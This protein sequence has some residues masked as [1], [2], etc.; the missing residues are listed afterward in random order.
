M[1]C[2]SVPDGN[3]NA[4]TKLSSKARCAHISAAALGVTSRNGHSE[5]R[6]SR[7]AQCGNPAQARQGAQSRFGAGPM[8]PHDF[9]SSAPNHASQ[10]ESD[11]DRIIRVADDRH[12]VGNEVDRDRQVAEPQEQSKPD[13]PAYG[14]IAAELADEPDRV[15][16]DSRRVAQRVYPVAV[17]P[18]RA[19]A[20]TTARR[21][22]RT[23]R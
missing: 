10:D 5:P 16:H 13:R 9:G 18:G 23:R 11:D 22:R 6:L 14:L 21:D 2:K 4:S 8:L 7:I 12:K 1:I 19:V 17:R 3:P 15:R 20:V